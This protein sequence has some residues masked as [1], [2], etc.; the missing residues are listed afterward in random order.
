MRNSDHWPIIRKLAAE[1]KDNNY[2]Y[3]VEKKTVHVHLVGAPM[4]LMNYTIKTDGYDV[5]FYTL[6]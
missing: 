1:Y 4:A 5:K 3:V 6:T 2:Y